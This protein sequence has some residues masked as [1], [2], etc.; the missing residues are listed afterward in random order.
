[1][2]LLDGII[3][4]LVRQARQAALAAGRDLGDRAVADELELD[5][6]YRAR[7][8]GSAAT[9]PADDE[10]DYEHDDEHEDDEPDIAA[11]PAGDAAPS[12]PYRQ[13]RPAS[14][15]FCAATWS[16]Q[17]KPVPVVSVI[18]PPREYATT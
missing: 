4:E 13:A 17:P 5:R 6:L 9:S 8:T 18:A 1:M 3:V 11:A 10:P 2:D 7:R 15:A 16:R 12:W 14:L